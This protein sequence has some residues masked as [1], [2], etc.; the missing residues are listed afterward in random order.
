MPEVAFRRAT[1]RVTKFTGTKYMSM[2]DGQLR[3]TPKLTTTA[4]L[5]LPPAACHLPACILHC[6]L[7]DLTEN[8]S[9]DSPTRTCCIPRKDSPGPPHTKK[10]ARTPG[11]RRLKCHKH[12]TYCWA[13]PCP[14]SATASAAPSNIHSSATGLGPLAKNEFHLTGLNRKIFAQKAFIT[15]LV[16]L[17]IFK[18]NLS[19]MA[20]GNANFGKTCLKLNGNFGIKPSRVVLPDPSSKGGLNMG[21]PRPEACLFG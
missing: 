10:P 6:I 16:V 7:D 12:V 20:P 8:S 15:Q 4:V 18:L 11:G 13:R 19:L 3:K 1:A 9:I 14:H 17:H 2:A 5:A 21:F